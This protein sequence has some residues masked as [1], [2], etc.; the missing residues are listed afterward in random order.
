MK[1]N[2]TKGNKG[3]GDRVINLTTSEK[4]WFSIYKLA[5]LA[6][7]LAIN[8]WKINEDAIKRTGNFFFIQAI[9][10]GRAHV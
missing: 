2:W 4:E 5:L 10:I 7:Q 3:N 8:E 9:K 1:I 6:N